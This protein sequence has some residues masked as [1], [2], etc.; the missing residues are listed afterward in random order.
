[1]RASAAKSMSWIM[2]SF[3]AAIV[4]G[5]CKQ[6]RMIVSEIGEIQVQVVCVW[7]VASRILGFWV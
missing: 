5:E 6:L 7:C 4:G 1:M 2:T 3:M